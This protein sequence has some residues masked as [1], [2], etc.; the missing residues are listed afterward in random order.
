MSPKTAWRIGAILLAAV[1]NNTIV[2]LLVLLALLVPLAMRLIIL[3][4]E[5]DD[6]KARQKY[7]S[8]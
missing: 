3:A 8:R 4:G 1:L 2:T 5:A 6:P 7:N